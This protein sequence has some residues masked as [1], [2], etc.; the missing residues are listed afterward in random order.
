MNQLMSINIYSVLAQRSKR[1][2][3]STIKNILNL[4]AEI[5]PEIT[6]YPTHIE[7]CIPMTSQEFNTKFDCSAFVASTHYLLPIM[8]YPNTESSDSL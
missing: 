7:V 5:Q 3:I 6:I 2:L 4:K 1:G 8:V